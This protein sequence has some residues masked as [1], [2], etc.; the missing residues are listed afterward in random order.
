MK[1]ATSAPPL[2]IPQL[3]SPPAQQSALQAAPTAPPH[4]LAASKHHVSL[5]CSIR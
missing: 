5:D 1:V 3:V 2:E 4:E